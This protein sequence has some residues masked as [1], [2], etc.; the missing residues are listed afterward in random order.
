M[1]DIIVSA[2]PCINS[3]KSHI[4]NENI[5]LEKYVEDVKKGTY[6]NQIIDV[7]NALEKFGKGSEYA[8]A[9]KIFL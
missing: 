5:S 6:I 9:K 3:K 4:I 7:R 8:E 2:F 1:K